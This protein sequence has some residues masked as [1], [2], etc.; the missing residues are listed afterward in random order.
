MGCRAGL[1][2][3]RGLVDGF[4]GIGL[5]D[6]SA[7]EGG[8]KSEYWVSAVVIVSSVLLASA[9]PIIETTAL[10]FRFSAASIC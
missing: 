3:V 7:V 1:L 6:V 4:S 2:L 10:S 8:A 5:F 9:V